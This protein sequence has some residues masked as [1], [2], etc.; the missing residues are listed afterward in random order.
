VLVGGSSG[1]TQG[2]EFKNPTVAKK[3]EKHIKELRKVK[4]SICTVDGCYYNSIA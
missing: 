1:R 4:R 2:P 3:K